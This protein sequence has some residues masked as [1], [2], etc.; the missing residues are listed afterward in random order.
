MA[1]NTAD[2][3]LEDETAKTTTKKGKDETAASENGASKKGLSTSLLIKI[4]VGL[5]VV[6]IAMV[7]AFFVFSSSPETE[8]ATAEDTEISETETPETAEVDEDMEEE[9]TPVVTPESGTIELPSVAENA[10]PTA[11]TQ[12][13]ATE[14]GSSLTASEVPA[15]QPAP[16]GSTSSDKVL[17][18]MVALQKQIS[19]MQQENQKLIKRVEELTKESDT[20]RARLPQSTS[21]TAA[22]IN[23]EQFVDNDDVPLYYRENRYSNTP[24]PEL[25]P[26]WGEFQQAR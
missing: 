19:A 24:Q 16:T 15:L 3:I 12:T 13:P 23:D 9:T 21:S 10:T 14:G 5:G 4:A 2:D 1:E 25:K 18:E 20:L 26:Q 7:V 6:L 8:S 11:A 17:S 22:P